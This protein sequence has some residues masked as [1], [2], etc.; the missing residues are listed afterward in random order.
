MDVTSTLADRAAELLTAQADPARAGQMAAYMKS[1][2]PFFGVPSQQRM[3]ISRK[4]VAEFPAESRREYVESVRSL[5]SGDH[6]E[7]KYLAVSYA[8]SFS[9]YVTLS[10]LPLYRTMI[11]E[12]A[13]WDFVDEIASHLVGEVLLNQR[14]KATHRIT[15]WIDDE[16]LWLRRTSIICQLRHKERTDTG[17]LERSCTQNLSDTDFFIRKAI[18]WALREFAKTEPDWVRAYVQEHRDEMSHLTAREA[19]K[20]LVT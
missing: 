16:D 12:G 2:A 18:G 17:L 1:E 11:Q 9:P 15:P 19:T 5:W 3:V 14:A 20:H 8:R 4:L 7:L 6:R 13:W 10:S